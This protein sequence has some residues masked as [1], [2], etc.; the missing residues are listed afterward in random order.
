MKIATIL[1]LIAAVF[2]LQAG[3]PFDNKTF[4]IM[5][6]SSTTP[7]RSWAGIIKERYLPE[8]CTVINTAVNGSAWEVFGTKR[9]ASI[10]QQWEQA[11]QLLQRQKKHAD[12][13]IITTGGN[14]LPDSRFSYKDVLALCSSDNAKLED[15]QLKAAITTLKKIVEDHPESE[16]YLISNFYAKSSPEKD[17]LRL[18]YRDQLAALCDYYSCHL[19]D[20]TRNSGIRGRLELQADKRI[21][22]T[23]RI[24]A[25]SEK[26]KE[27]IAR[28][29]FAAISRDFPMPAKS[30]K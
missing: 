20:L 17:S 11:K 19:I 13:I 22:T 30:K 16:I 9:R 23:D 24:H 27:R 2:M 7:T 8:S 1:A 25:Y 12:I 10:M 15:E 6:D 5:G 26:G 29:V 14:K 28:L 4:V 3:N 21:F 18:I